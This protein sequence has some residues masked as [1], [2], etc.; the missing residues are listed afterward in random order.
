MDGWM[1]FEVGFTLTCH[2]TKKWRNPLQIFIRKRE[3]MRGNAERMDACMH[4]NRSAD[5]LEK[6]WI[7]FP[8]WRRLFSP[9]HLQHGK[10]LSSQHRPNRFSLSPWLSSNIDVSSSPSLSHAL[11]S[12]K[13]HRYEFLSTSS[14]DC[15][16]TWAL[17]SS[18]IS[19]LILW[20]RP[21]TNADMM[22]VCASP[23]S[24]TLVHPILSLSLSRCLLLNKSTT[25]DHHRYTYILISAVE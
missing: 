9:T 21:W 16:L 6:K 14:A 3:Q 24:P 17:E 13:C 4:R 2:H 1:N 18:L 23:N 15:S 10:T 22:T 8:Q 5:G 25:G 20:K 12:P 19:L 11:L 7:F